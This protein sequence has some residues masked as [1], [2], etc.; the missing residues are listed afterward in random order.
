MNKHL[1]NVHDMKK[2]QQLN[3]KIISGSHEDIKEQA[4]LEKNNFNHAPHTFIQI[5]QTNKYLNHNDDE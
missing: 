2:Q 5:H 1:N 4:G 3:S